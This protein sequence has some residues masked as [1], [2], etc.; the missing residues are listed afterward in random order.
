MTTE[1]LRELADAAFV[2]VLVQRVLEKLQARRKNALVVYTGSKIAESVALESMGRLRKEGFNFRVLMSRSAAQLL[3]VNE[4]RRV[5]EP[6]DLWIDVPGDTPE[7]LTQRYDTIVVPAMTI[8]TASHVSACMADTPASAIILEG[9]MR[10]KNVVINIDGCCPDN[11]VREKLGFRFPEPMKQVLRG[12]LETLRSFGARLT[13]SEKLCEKT[14]KA[15]QLGPVKGSAPAKSAA[16][17]KPQLLSTPTSITIK[18]DGKIF[19]GRHLRGVPS[20]CSVKIPK[21]TMITQL[22]ADEARRRGITI[23]KEA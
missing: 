5:L 15:I 2:Q 6:E 16:P 8:H 11:P 17:A 3:N 10:A 4:I 18:L 22:A 9:L 1:Q 20:H 14:L 21:G 7:A 13:T 12:H 23:I 19:S